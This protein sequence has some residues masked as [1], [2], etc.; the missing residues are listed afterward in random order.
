MHTST[1]A[2]G[3]LLAAFDFT[4][5]GISAV[6]VVA[7]LA[8]GAVVASRWKTAA[9]NTILVRYGRKYLTKDS[10]GVMVERG[11]KSVTGGG[12]F[13]MPVVEQFQLMS[14]AAF[15]ISIQESGVPTM[16]N[17]PVAIEA[18]ATCRISP[19][20]DEQANAIQAFLGKEPVAI[21]QTISE[22]L[23][24]H[25]RSIIA[26]L[27]VEQILRD[28]AE[29]NKRVLEESGDEFKRLGVQIVTLVVQDVSDEEGYIKALGKQ[30]TAAIIRDAAIATAQAEKTTKIE[31]S[32]AQ[33]E[34]KEV[35]AQNAA[36][37]ADA[38]KDRD[39]QIA[40][41][42]VQ[43]ERKKAEADMSNA[44]AKTQQETTLRVA[45][46][47]RDTDAAQAGIAVQEQ[48]AILKQK[49]LDA[50]VIVE[51]E[52]QR[53]AS[54]ISADAANEVA[55]RGAKQLATEAEGKRNASITEA[56]GIA[57]K[58]EMVAA[59][60]AAATRARLTSEADGAKAVQLANAEGSRANLL[61]AAEGNERGL[62]AIA[63]GKE[64]DLLAQATGTR[65]LAEA[66]KQLNESGQ[67][68]MILDRV[69]LL[70]E[71]G[72]DA[73]A[74]V[75]SAAFGPLGQSLGAIKN[76]SI[77]D[78]GGKDGQNGV[79]KFAGSIP[80]AIAAMVANAQALGID[81]KPLLKLLKL[82]PSKL[83]EMIGMVDQIIPEAVVTPAKQD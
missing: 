64:A 46:A 42:R 33:R 65:E 53:R 10:S 22:I 1:L 37:V 48:R 50:T 69:P 41:F 83:S 5:I 21:S 20:P 57:K 12:A 74:K 4:L 66:L 24:G 19:N 23:R 43:T 30:E 56:E 81:V 76:V 82:D 28:R 3:L 63:K 54:I 44:I 7:I 80:A 55:Q 40:E 47:K 32:N 36:K 60:D 61:A 38:E 68:L 14:T 78:M 13:I 8:L 29:F 25:V 35:D 49:E 73:G 27:T 79:G 34:A 39:I 45:E 58:T 11:F 72:G 15:Q 67:L 17:V 70:L 77:V 59:A 31:V 9:P 52:T 26:S 2:I 18:M 62:L 75:V 16:K 71:K 51:A 6:V